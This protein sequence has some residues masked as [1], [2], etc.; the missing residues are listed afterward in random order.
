MFGCLW[1]KESFNNFDTHAAGSE[2]LVAF[3]ASRRRCFFFSFRGARVS[4]RPAQWRCF[5]HSPS[6]RTG[7]FLGLGRFSGNSLPELMDF[8]LFGKTILVVNK[9]FKLFLASQLGSELS[10]RLFDFWPVH[11]GTSWLL[12]KGSQKETSHFVGSLT[13]CRRHTQLGVLKIGVR[14]FLASF[15]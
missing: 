2:A 9:K 12:S 1:T 3:I 11:S 5:S 10:K 4:K 6:S 8:K 13:G 14:L 15:K 7:H